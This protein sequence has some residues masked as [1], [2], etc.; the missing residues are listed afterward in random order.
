MFETLG[1]ADGLV[2][3]E[4]REEEKAALFCDL[5]N[6]RVK[7]ALAFDFG[8]LVGLDRS[9]STAIFNS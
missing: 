5:V 3:L 1:P 8:F 2:K 4:V 7:K 9:H 6:H